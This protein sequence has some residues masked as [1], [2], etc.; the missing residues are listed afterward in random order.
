MGKNPSVFHGEKLLKNK[1][2]VVTMEQGVVGHNHP[3]D[4]VTWDD[5]VEFSKRL[6][7]SLG[8]SIWLCLQAPN[9]GRMGVRVLC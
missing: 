9:R 5:A 1:K 2:I 8:E 3:F 6:G 7:E 4:H